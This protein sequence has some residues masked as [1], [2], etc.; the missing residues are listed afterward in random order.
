MGNDRLV[1]GSG[2]D[3]AVFSSRNNTINIATTRRQTTGDGKDILTG[4]ENVKGGGGDDIIRGNNAANT[5]MGEDDADKLYGNNGMIN[6]M[7]D[8][9]D[10]LNGGNGNDRLVGG[11]GI[12][13]A[14][15][16]SKNNRIN[17]VPLADKILVM[18]KIF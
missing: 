16:S 2:K 6:S 3:T 1:G 11:D 8:G 7:V 4:I 12:D 15:F 18:D 14:V 9:N 10:L 17:L 13:T 5:L